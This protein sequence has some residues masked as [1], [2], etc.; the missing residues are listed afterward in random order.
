MLLAI[1]APVCKLRFT[2]SADIFENISN[3]ADAITTSASASSNESICRIIKDNVQ[4]YI[5]DKAN[6]YGVDLT[7]DVTLSE[8]E[9][10]AP[11]SVSLTGDV[12]PYTKRLLSEMIEKDLGIGTEAQI[13]N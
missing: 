11:V 4:A 6:S 5:L 7:V 1:V 9:I 13:W 12:A 3:Q 2:A 8:G 10:P